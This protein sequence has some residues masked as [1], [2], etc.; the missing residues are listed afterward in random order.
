MSVY[1]GNMVWFVG[2]V[3]D[4]RDPEQMGRVKVRCFG[5]HSEDK[6]VL[7]TEDLPWASLMLPANSAGTGSIGQSA[8]GIVQ[9]A[10][11]V[12]FFTDGHNMQQPLI[13]GVLPSTPYDP[14]VKNNTGFVDPAGI[15]P[16]NNKYDNDQPL[17]STAFFKDH[18]SYYKR[19][20]LRQ[21]DIDT[22]VPPKVSTVAIDKEDEYYD[23]DVWS[24]PETH[25]GIKPSY[26]FNKVL[27]SE[28]GHTT[29]IDDTP[30]NPRI[31]QFHTSGTSY[32]INS[33]EG[34]AYGDKTET[35]NGNNYQ[36]VIKDN[37]V[38]IKGNMN[39]TVENDM[40]VLVKGN[41]HL[42][43]EKDYTVNVKG[44]KQ[45][46]IGQSEFKE[47]DEGDYVSNVASGNYTQRIAGV[48]TRIV[49][50][51]IRTTIGGKEERI[52]K[53]DYGRVVIGNTTTVTKKNYNKTVTGTL[54]LLSLGDL[55]IETAA[56]M[57]TDVD[58]NKTVTVQ[59]GN[60]TE[61][62]NGNQTTQITG[63]LDVDA[64]RIDLN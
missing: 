62:I 4:R 33:T 32:E 38:Y 54:D 12:G 53:N 64:T 17:S 25:L 30:D 19:E 36:I 58:G 47:I 24:T 20:D 40:K 3:E 5:I 52:I 10:W 41:Y 50:S 46:K 6:N 35:I 29:E 34:G 51:D 11:V 8:T 39:L 15:N 59:D 13:M 43:V 31:A 18:P 22:A 28:S 9:G 56:N 21:L 37:N 42:E 60:V 14:E 26:P 63:N 7:R 44:S 55:T 16:V 1:S 61:N 23:R 2:A 57:T 48:E 27:A 49:D 45:T